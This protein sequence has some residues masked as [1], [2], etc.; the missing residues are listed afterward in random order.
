MLSVS[1]PTTVAATDLEMSSRTHFKSS[2]NRKGVVSTRKY[3]RPLAEKKKVN[4]HDP[5]S[6][7]VAVRI[8]PLLPFEE[9]NQDCMDVYLTENDTHHQGQLLKSLSGES[10]STFGTQTTTQGN[11]TVSGHSISPSPS[12][13]S[14]NSLQVREAKGQSFTFDN[15]FPSRTEQ[16]EIYEQSVMPL[17]TSCIEGYN[18][19][20]LAYGQTGSGKTHTILGQNTGQIDDVEGTRSNEGVIPRGLRQLFNDLNSIK[21]KF[22]RAQSPS[23]EYP[24]INH[25]GTVDSK[26]SRRSSSHHSRKNDPYEYQVK[27]QFLELYGEE[28]RDLLGS[29]DD[30]PSDIPRSKPSL[31][32]TVSS[33]VVISSYKSSKP[34][35]T[36]R[37]SRNGEDAEVLGALTLKVSSADEALEYLRKG[38]SKRVVGKTAMN[39]VSSRSHVVFT[40]IV[41][42]TWRKQSN[43]KMEVEMKTSKIHFV[44]LSGSERIKR[45]NTKGKRYVNH[46]SHSYL[47]VLHC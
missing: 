13:V 4:F 17:V 9:G 28:I 37:D 36:L 39:A 15:V 18:A 25:T 12:L 44:D 11:D 5:S 30:D 26:V 6:V 43:E 34:T 31:R 1:S 24:S 38:L 27:I 42:Q 2:R 10:N 7:K 47:M 32:R 45:S 21:S 22:T 19:T 35:I 20:I 14:Y 40:A 3:K 8:R 33:P 41:Q 29:T 23:L 46:R 16:V